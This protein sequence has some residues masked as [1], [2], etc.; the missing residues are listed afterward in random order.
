MDGRKQR[1]MVE[2]RGEVT[3]VTFVDKKILDESN[4]Q[5]IGDQLF[6]LIEKHYKIDLLLNFENVEYLSSA[7]LGKLITLNKKVKA[8]NGKLKLCC[9]R[10]QIYDVFKITKL[11]K[12]FE[13]HDTEERAL[14]RF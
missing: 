10:P 14:A 2:P 3:I 11:N 4:I 12:L 7:A 13:I 1:L 6:E 9:I 8:E 5:D